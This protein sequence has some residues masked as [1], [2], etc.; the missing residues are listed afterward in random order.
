MPNDDDM[1]ACTIAAC[2]LPMLFGFA[3]VVGTIGT[4]LDMPWIAG[5]TAF[6]VAIL[7][8]TCVVGDRLRSRYIV[9]SS[10]AV[11]VIVGLMSW[12]VMALIL[13]LPTR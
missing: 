8:M 3:L 11:G 2:C 7:A 4:P 10:V 5:G 1:V 6:L 9:L 12:A 13:S